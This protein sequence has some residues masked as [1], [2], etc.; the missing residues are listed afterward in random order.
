MGCSTVN[1]DFWKEQGSILR[2]GASELGWG[3]ASA[4][5]L[6]SLGKEEKELISI[7]NILKPKKDSVPRTNSLSHKPLCLG[8]YHKYSTC[9][10]V[11]L[12]VSQHK[13]Y[14]V[15][16]AWLKQI[17]LSLSLK[18]D[19]DTRLTALSP[20]WEG[21]NGAPSPVPS[22]ATTNAGSFLSLLLPSL[23]SVV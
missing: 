8:F 11:P 17:I 23:D 16:V 3:N 1:P 5:L 2:P 12:S 10:H 7:C 4:G 9:S 19:P 21:I 15:M 6:L 22:R 20:G 14:Y 13:L 18:W